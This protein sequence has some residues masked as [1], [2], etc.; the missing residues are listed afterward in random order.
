M[1]QNFDTDTDIAGEGGTSET[2]AQ[3]RVA[4]AVITHPRR[5]ARPLSHS[6]LLALLVTLMLLSVLWAAAGHAG[7]AT[8][9]PEVRNYQMREVA[10]DDVE[11]RR[12]SGVLIDAHERLPLPTLVRADHHE[13]LHNVHFEIDIDPYLE[14][15][16]IFD[17]AREG[18]PL[19][20][21]SRPAKS[22]LITQAINGADLYLNG[23]WLDGYA[24]STTSARFMWF[25]PLVAALPRKLLR[26]DRRNIVTVEMTSWEP[27]FTLAPI[28]IG[29]AAQ[30][31][32]IAE[33]ID[34]IGG[35]LTDASKAF[36]LLAGL[37]MV[38]V[39]LANRADP[40]FGLIGM[41]SLTWAMVYTLS[42]WVYMPASWRTFWLWSFYLCAGALNVMLVQFILR[43]VD[44]PPSRRATIALVGVSAGAAMIWPF[45]GKLVEWNLDMLW[46]WVLVPFQAWA[47]IGLALH[48]KRTRDAAGLLLLIAVLAAGLLILHDYNVLMRIVEW[49]VHTG[50]WSLLQLFTA[51]VYLTHL[52]LPPLL[53][54][55][56]R[57]HLSKYRVSVE[58]VRQANIILAESLRRREME[59]A[60][61]YDRQ[62]DLERREAAQ[63][64]R[65]R[66]YT[67][68]H[69]G[70]GSRLVATIFS[71]REGVTERQQLERNLLDV[72]QGV[73][74]VI[75]ETDSTE[76]RE[77][78]SILF[79]YCLNLD[80]LLSAPDFQVEYDIEDGRECVL[81]GELSKEVLRIVEESVA[82]TLKY[83]RASQVRITL[84]QSDTELVLIVKDNGDSIANATSAVRPFFGASTGHGLANM[85]QRTLRM[86]GTY[87]FE[88]GA[89]GATTTLTLPL[90]RRPSGVNSNGARS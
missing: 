22:L 31:A 45:A 54:V 61:S 67:E 62:R 86:G 56:A 3:A 9:I 51:P 69:D 19:L 29:Q 65:E 47:V 4:S 34:F 71:V 16:D 14:P 82:N 27:F 77:I 74:N 26:R 88:R 37:F 72:L 68:L 83:A 66:I 7:L 36:C 81:L 12:M 35:S 42:L 10:P 20:P 90:A 2:P 15:A 24:R 39:W 33:T 21:S 85:R 13:A 1:K 11:A 49:P 73:R 75:N 63:E 78:Q 48:V 76:H 87:H 84:H 40:A 58:H 70:I 5:H 28:Y 30:I 79:D 43:Y 50:S 57:V 52:A 46:I 38:G 8:S 55:M 41:A 17:P 64:E 32:Y 53:I 6:A 89:R 60:V 59:L 18:D 44:R 23:V 80:S 25:R